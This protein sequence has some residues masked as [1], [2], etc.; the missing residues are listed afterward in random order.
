M[1]ENYY[2]SVSSFVDKIQWIKKLSIVILMLLLS[3]FSNPLVA[4]TTVPFTTSSTWLCPAGV[5][6][7]QVEA[8][9]AGG[10]GGGGGTGNKDGGGGGGGGAYINNN[11][12]A[13]TPGVTYTITVGN[14]GNGGG[15]NTNGSPGAVTT[16][17]FDAITITPNSG[18]GGFG[19]SNGAA[20]GAGGAAGTWKGGNGGQ[21]VNNTR[22]GGGGGGAGSTAIGTDASNA[23]T[24][25]G[26]GGA[27]N[28]TG[29]G[30]TG[31]TANGAIGAA[32]GIIG[33]GAAGGT[34][35]S[36]G[37]NG[38]RGEIR[39]TYTLPCVAPASQATGFVL[40][41]VTS[42]SVPASFSGAANGYL[43]IQSLTNTLPA[44]PSNGT[45]YNGGNIG[46]LGAGLTFIQSGASTAIP[47]TG[48]NG[49]TRYYYFIFA[50][51]NTACSGGPIYNTSSPLTGNGTTC[52]AVPNTV[53]SVSVT[54]SGFTI[55][56]A[57]P[58]GGNSSAIT[59][60]L[61]ITTNAAYT[62]N[63]PGSPFTIADP[64]VIKVVTGLASNTIYYYRIL[65]SNGC[66]SA[67][68]TGNVTTLL[69]ACI[70][71]AS[72]AS[73][74]VLGTITSTAV[75]ASFSGTANGYLVI[76]SLTNTLPAQPSNGTIYNAGNIGTLG[77]GLTFIQSSASTAIPGTGLNGNTKYFY[78][79]F[80][81]NNTACSG[82]PI[83]NASS[84]LTGNGTTCPAVPNTVATASVTPNGFTINWAYPTGGN[85][86]AITYT[87]QITTNAAY[88]ANIP[89]SPF[90]IADPTVTKVV[91]GLASNTIYYYRILA[92]NGCSS[93]YVTGNVTTLLPACI[94]PATQATGFVVGT[95][96]STAVPATF[97]GTANG[98]LVIRS[99][100]NT[101][102]TQ[103]INGTT[104]TAGNIGTLGAGLT[105]VQSGAS[106]T[107]TGTGL[108]GNTKYYY[109]IFNYNNT[110]CSGGP[111]Y[112]TLGPLTGNG[113]TCPAVPNLVTVSNNL[114]TGFTI[115]WVYPTGGNSNAIT[116]TLQITTNAA[117][118]ANIP[119]SPFSIAD[120]INT[121]VVTGLNP[122]TIY[123]YR[124][125]ANNG[126]SSAYVTGN[127]TTLLTPCFAPVNQA[128]GFVLGTTTSTAVPATF[129]GTANGYLV[130][131]SLTNTPP[132]QPIN[133]TIYTAGTIGTLGSGLT[134]I[135]SGASTTITGTGLTG[136]TKYYYFIYA[137]NATAC[138]GGPIY[139]A[140][141][142]LTG[143][144]TTC[145][146][147][148][149]SVAVTSTTL[150]GFT[151][152]WSS[153]SGGNAS[154]I[155][156]TV[157]VTTDAGYT[158]NIAGS[159][160]AVVNPI[161][162]KVITGLAA[163]T[164]YYYRILANN[165]C[166]SAWVNGNAYTGY[167]LSTSTTNG[168]FI[169]NFTTTG[170]IS[171]IAN[172]T[173]Y[174]TNGYGN[175]TAQSASQQPYGTVNFT[176]AYSGGT[177]GFNIWID[178]NDDLDFDDANE[179]VYSS[180]NYFANNAGTFAVP[181]FASVGNHRMRIRADF[182][183]TN[184][185]Y[186]GVITAGETEDYTF[187][188]VA[189]PCAGNPSN[190]NVTAINYTTATLNWNAAIPA[191][192]NGYQYYYSTSGTPPV[193]AS[194]ASGA[195]AAG[196]L[197]ANITGLTSGTLYNVWVR[198][199]CGA[200]KGVWVG[201]ISFIT[202]TAP[203]VT[204]DASFCQ[205]GSGTISA[206][207]SCTNLNNLGTTINGG[208]DA[209]V[210]PRAIRP[211]IFLANSPTCQFDG[212]GLTSNY[213]AQDFQ[214][215]ITGNYV[216]TMAP[217]TA[218][219]SMGYI[220]VNPFNP[221]VC[222]SGTWVV[223]DDDSGPTAFEPQ[224]NA[225]LTAGVTYT[226]ISTLYSG[227]N[228]LLT[229]T[230]QWNVT[231]PPGGFIS[232]VSSGAI[233]WYTTP[234]GGTAIG[235]GTPFNPVGVPG[236]GLTN[237]NTP[238]TTTYYAA[239]PSNP[240][241]RSP[242][243]FVINGPTST[244]S[245]N[246]NI[247]SGSTSISIALTGASPW[248]F[249][250]TNGVTPI[251]VVG[252]VT[253]P[254]VFS[255]SPLVPTTY[256]V[257]ALSDA[258]CTALA[259]NRMGTASVNSALTWNG[260]I[261]NDWNNPSNWSSN[262]IP[263][264]VDCVLIPNV[265]NPPVI[266]GTSYAAYAYSLTIQN[267]GILLVNPSNSI[268]VTDI[269]DIN[270]GGQF[271]IK[272]SASLVQINN[273][274][275]IG[276]INI[277][278]IT[279]PMYRF[280]YTYWGCPVTLASGYTLGM[281]SP[282]TLS[283]KY[284]SWI[285]TVAN[286]FGNW[287]YE[288]AATVMD[289]IKGY[290]IRAPQN[291]SYTSNVKV[292]YTANFIG[293]PNN[294]DILC[295]IYYGGLPLANNNDKY[296]LLGNP[297]ASAVDAELFLSDPANVPIIDGTIYFWTHNSPPSALNIDP[298]YG[299]FLINY[300]ANDYASWNKLGGTGTTSAAGSGGTVPSGFIAS[301]QGFFTKST[302]TATSGDPVVFKNS[303]RITN[304]NNQFFRSANV[305]VNSN[306]SNL[307]TFEKHRIWLNL[308]N[309]GGSFNQI[310]VGY[311]E[312]A[313]N[314]YD[315]DFD[316][317][318]FTDNNSI[319]LYSIIPDKHLVIQGR[320]L[321]FSIEDQIPLGYKSTLNDTFSIRIDHFDG[322]FE[323][324]NIYLEDRLLNTIHDLKLSPYVFT[325][326]IGTFDDRFVI[327][328]NTT[329]LSTGGF[330]NSN[331]LIS[332]F[333]NGK[334]EINSSELIHEVD[335][336]DISG[337]L[338]QHFNLDIPRTNFESHFSIAEGIYILKVKLQNGGLVSQKLIY[339]K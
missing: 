18:A 206:V 279:Q 198:S 106:T 280:D 31:S 228:I 268:T 251:T 69:P 297:Y 68:V 14:G 67:Y 215:N 338:I 310:I 139:N 173:G 271:Y 267:G 178:W 220:V 75:P 65:A 289:P 324:Q 113:T 87:L 241:L 317:V 138:S 232:G 28:L 120:P 208:W 137:Y 73:G 318:R 174:S 330:E 194:L 287:F 2:N 316:G 143:N 10:G 146:D 179:K 193:P 126:C 52:P 81:Y 327:R 135:Q 247:C 315:R 301:G 129:S 283:D 12:V 56:W 17:S 45:I 151:L 35:N 202:L 175:F 111:V 82:G 71:P 149:Y 153:P 201:P 93:A 219:D 288:S 154:P 83:Y 62:A 160:F 156:Y 227:A 216:F 51:N 331:H 74:F 30:G 270:S 29:D 334:L 150:S 134:F 112:N 92:S 286:S 47:G 34:R 42:T 212:A 80:A 53:A 240:S 272:D 128:S 144:G 32:G 166:S 168:F 4:Q 19:F 207:A 307:N 311:A 291:F 234:N 95:I 320:A 305:A 109:F 90:T 214:V 79:I 230:F 104:Y 263:T 8:W 43:V 86:S 171:N 136:N 284:F 328:Y 261:D 46:T 337:K 185:A 169:N 102:P 15:I 258:N 105:F 236:S 27:G 325:S 159:P 246:G 108:N 264:A 204:T 229:N 170:G 132:T 244:M 119:G 40:G 333:K 306:R 55:N 274:N 260:S 94:T 262:S 222:G 77:A 189:L 167:C 290:I 296:N 107:I 217:T 224:M 61:Q 101:P 329:V 5:T 50:Y 295:P 213:A 76:Q 257:I 3:L 23:N 243:N 148:P 332:N 180:G 114:S 36:S 339:K 24:N 131:Q 242:A 226:L 48:L 11:T 302:G 98:Y 292:P 124:I 13:V 266:S 59:Y 237:T 39:I 275:N 72:Q 203:P 116:Y 187:T 210:D 176:S 190:I 20:G 293:T 127:N 88:T 196:V 265:T 186:C 209:N 89:G 165:G 130:I 298:F 192:A 152:N 276:T 188:V 140:L 58:T 335:V 200:N 122:N 321:P 323:N 125:L 6:T 184:P 157:Q 182:L 238:G 78:F 235:T 300:A 255:V 54:P 223:G 37:G 231:A 250:Y 123:Y 91:T 285:P 41:T 100:T 199:N 308:V 322:L 1:K 319:T 239:C 304:N 117:Y 26:N 85:F 63:I 303:M 25:P 183:S 38:A 177:F 21:G 115:N 9:G 205:G 278:R 312:G 49:N 172:A 99:L 314:S 336:F 163:S 326:A 233:Q 181:S 22:S 282:L 121:K 259:I 299:D 269:V 161:T 110:A 7:I 225:I 158:V 281:L 245:G 191:P 60:T 256:S 16:A 197:T 254:Y 164:T 248:T 103:P 249:T 133:G 66:S 70:A 141:G 118:T 309:N 252:N 211:I 155:T 44:Q 97:S 221:G 273:T 64:T 84:P 277:E 96:T 195:T 218:Y 142:P 57:Y 145:P 253:N 33:G 147:I 313:S 162:T 294:G